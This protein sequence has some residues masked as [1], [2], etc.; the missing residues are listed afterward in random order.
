[1]FRNFL[2][3]AWRNITRHKGFSAINIIGLAA[4]LTVCILIGLF[5]WDESRYDTT[6][7]DNDRIYRVY[8]EQ[9]D[10]T[11]T[12]KLAV[13]PPIFAT[14]L[15][16][17]YPEVEQTVRILMTSSFK[18]LFEAGDKKIYEEHGF[19]AD[20]TF[21]DVFRLNFLAGSRENALDGETGIV[22]SAEMAHRLWGNENPVGKQVLMNKSPYIVKG[23]FQKEPRFHL[24][25]NYVAPLAAVRLDASRMSSWHWHQFFT[26][27]R[28]KPATNAAS[29]ETKFQNEVARIEKALPDTRGVDK[30][31]LQ[32][33]RKIHLYSA[34]FKFDNAARGNSTYVKALT[35]I[36]VFILVIACFNFVN[37][38]TARSL[39]RAKEVGVRKTIGAGTNQLMTQFIGETIFL[40]LISTAIALALTAGTLP[41][42]N[43]FTGKQIPFHIL[44]HPVTGAAL[45]ALVLIVGIL[46]GF[47][48]ALMLSRFKPVNVLKAN[49]AAAGQPVRAAWIRMGLIVVQFA[50]SVLLIISALIVFRQVDYLH[51]KDLGFSKDQI[52]FFPMR[53]DKMF[54]NSETFRNELLR[55]PGVSS[56]S[57][58][59]GYPGDAVAG[60][61]VIALHNGEKETKSATQLTVDYDY[62]KT[63]GLRVIAGRDFS[64][65]MAGDKD[66]A[67]IINET[68]VRELGFQT[69][70]KALGQTLQWHPW[71]AKNP[72]SLKTGQIIGVVQDFNYKSLY[73]KVQTAVIQIFPDAAWK[74]AVKLHAGNIAA[75]IAG[76]T[77]VW[78]EFSPEYPLE[79]SFLDQSFQEMYTA[80]DKLNTLLW[81]FT[82]LAIFVGCLGLFGLAAYT[83]ERRRKEVGIRKV[84]G[85][86]TGSVVLLL[87]KDFIRLV[88]ISLLIASPIAWYCMNRWLLGFAYRIDIGWSVFALTGIAVVGIAF[89]TVG[90]QGIKAALANPVRTLHTE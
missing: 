19:F 50:L 89:I 62:I 20:S 26:Y 73:D 45:L 90:F 64:R 51:N 82:G 87:S 41:W 8:T 39:Q 17:D 37:L 11:A 6:V 42:L 7:P 58:G 32:P 60:D 36:A 68:A 61:E 81:V 23:I 63:L 71:G 44:I 14:T 70:Q 27:I 55:S 47:Y 31:F 86:T 40:A 16:K 28:L 33:M 30:P 18:T 56:V 65:E 74:V 9:S 35:L 46:A 54:H 21:F 34:D 84:L 4:G 12:Q 15:R 80:E 22:M 49:T 52:L 48:P 57:I 76:I 24:Q 3:V 78:N 66:H 25:F 13:T 79:Y 75:S 5:V 69:P 29:L 77:A 2:L 53:G 67:W 38:A 1:M 72:D 83:A 59:Y 85:A 10:N 88:V 43:R